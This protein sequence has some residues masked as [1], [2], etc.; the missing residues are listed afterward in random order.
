MFASLGTKPLQLISVH[1]IGLFAAR[2]FADPSSYNGRAVSLAGDELTYEEAQQ[3]FNKAVGYGMPQTWMLV[4]S[5]LQFI[6]K[7]MGT[8]FAWFRKEGYG[9][10]IAALRKE[11]PQL[12]D[13]STWLKESSDFAEK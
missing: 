3:V 4:G 1:D 8:M 7:E 11:E 5:L 2:A 13:L 10:D 12:Q 6:S 9:A